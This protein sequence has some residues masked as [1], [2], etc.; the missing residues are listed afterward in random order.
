MSHK[1]RIESQEALTPR[2]ARYRQLWCAE[3][4]E[5]DHTLRQGR[6]IRATLTELQS[7]F[8]VI[9]L[10]AFGVLNLGDG[11]ISGA[12]EAVAGLFSAGR[13]VRVVSNNASQSPARMAKKLKEWGFPFTE[14][15]II[16]SGMAVEP[17]VAGEARYRDRPYLLVG[18]EES[19][20]VYAPHPE[21][22]MVNREGA[23]LAIEQAEYILF[24]SNRDYHGG[25][26]ESDAR[27]L[28]THRR[29]PLLLAN[30]DLV[31]PKPDGRLEAVAGYAAMDLVER[32]DL[33]IDGIGKPFAPI[34][35]LV[36]E[37]FPDVAPERILMV[38]DTLDTDV[39][40]A[41]A[42]GFASCLT[43]SGA[44]AGW[45]ADLER[46]CDARGIR[47][48]YVIESLAG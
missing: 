35:Q 39:L 31:T 43:L 22:L 37:E 29:V 9:L 27:R 45:G 26:Q 14:A 2:Y 33:I 40:G 1:P 34:F 15:H 47:P 6:M 16:S 4:P 18:S 11:V 23:A 38:G 12:P 24:C 21:A 20:T 19:A 41:A 36:K 25:Q 30:P 46:L 48:D 5:L 3:H 13:R 10:D 17:F 44:C 28:L 42:Q 8:E 7:R 32:F